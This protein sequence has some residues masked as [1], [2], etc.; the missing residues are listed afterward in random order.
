MEFEVTVSVHVTV[1]IPSYVE[2]LADSLQ[3]QLRLADKMERAALTAQERRSAAQQQQR[4]LEPQL[5]K[6]REQTRELQQQV[7]LL[8]ACYSGLMQACHL[9][10]SVVCQVSQSISKRYDNRMV[11]IMGEINTI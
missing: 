2:R 6:L 3:Q 1:N 11:N 4:E 7:S 10:F 5:E 9:M 8:L